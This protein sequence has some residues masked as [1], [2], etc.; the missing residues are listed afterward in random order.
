MMEAH[1]I[2]SSFKG[3]ELIPPWSDGQTMVRNADAK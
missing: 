3:T 1:V 2:V